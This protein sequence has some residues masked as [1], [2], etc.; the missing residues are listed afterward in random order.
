MAISANQVSTS[1]TLEKLRQEFNKL[2]TDVSGLDSGTITVTTVGVQSSDFANDG[3]TVSLAGADLTGNKTITFPDI[4]G[5][6]LTDAN[7]NLG[8]ETTSSGDA[9]HVLIND[10]GVL[11]RI[12]PS[13]LG[14]GGVPAADDITA[15]NSNVNLT[16]S[17]GQ[18]NIG[19]AGS[20]QDV[21][22]KGTDS[23]GNTNFVAVNVDM[24]ENGLVTFSDSIKIKN[25][26][27]IGNPTAADIITLN[28]DTTVTFKDDIKIKN[29]GT[30]GSVGSPNAMS[31]SS[32]G[33]VTFN[34]VPALP[35]ATPFVF[36]TGM[37]VPYAGVIANQAAA[38][39]LASN[40]WLLCDGSEVSATTYAALKA[41]LTTT[42][43]AYTNGSGGSG[44]SHFRLPDLRGRVIAA[45]DN[46]GGSS[47]NV[48]TS[49]EAD[50]LGQVLGAQEHTLTP[51]QT[52]LVGHGHTATSTATSTST[53]TSTA[54]STSIAHRTSGQS[55]GSTGFRDVAG[56]TGIINQG[57]VITTNT[58]VTTDTTTTTNVSTTVDAATGANAS[59]PHPLV[60]PTMFMNYIIKT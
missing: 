2:R 40:G 46:M 52:A 32:G 34:S 37:I 56:G 8:A 29:S 13:D 31:V 24:S 43:G 5:T 26:G 59:S 20:D 19:P 33:V 30:I 39:A 15:G 21:N 18:I 11:K 4:N 49:T 9:D 44:T 3:F 10:G 51:S 23:D 16:T 36:L 53:S 6:I 12:T 42:Y 41:L 27:T 35:A 47:A 25:N 60:Q 48:V 7:A 28:S 50:N 38:L 17:S 22:I 45:L 55:A 57:G 1:D 14:I 58:D 54:T